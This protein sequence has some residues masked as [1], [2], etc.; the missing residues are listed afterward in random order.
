MARAKNTVETVQITISTTQR[1]RELLEVLT[2]EG[3]YGRNVA[4]TASLLISEKM[5]EMR[6]LGEIDD[7]STSGD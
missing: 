7:N 4:E 5:R 3:L 1:V 6:R 2:E